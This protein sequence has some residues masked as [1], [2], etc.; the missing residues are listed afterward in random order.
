MKKLK[1]KSCKDFSTAEQ[2]IHKYKLK[3]QI[4][5]SDCFEDLISEI[6]FKAF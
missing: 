1:I 6:L 4:F 5:F 3:S 2:K